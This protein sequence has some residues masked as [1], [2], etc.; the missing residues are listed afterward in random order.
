MAAVK[1]VHCLQSLQKSLSASSVCL[2]NQLPVVL[3]SNQLPVVLKQ[4]PPTAPCLTKVWMN[5]LLWLPILITF[6]F[7]FLFCWVCDIGLCE[8]ALHHHLK[9]GLPTCISNVR[10]WAELTLN[11]G[12]SSNILN[13]SELGKSMNIIPR[14]Y[15]FKK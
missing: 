10:N 5:T 14:F 1:K 11:Y 8:S 15:V 7:V 6:L 9:P 12:K 4:C 3:L 13:A 2:S